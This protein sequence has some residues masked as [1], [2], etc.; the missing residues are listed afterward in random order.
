MEN[1][2]GDLPI[3]HAV[4][5]AYEDEDEDLDDGNDNHHRR[6]HCLRMYA[7]EGHKHDAFDEATRGG[8]LPHYAHSAYLDYVYFLSV[9]RKIQEIN[10]ISDNAGNNGTVLLTMQLLLHFIRTSL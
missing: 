4:S 8:L 5:H 2:Y 10:G 3:D 1:D 7:E 6:I 9:Q